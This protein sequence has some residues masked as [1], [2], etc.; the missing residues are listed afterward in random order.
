MGII[1]SYFFMILLV[2]KIFP[3]AKLPMR[4]H[5]DD[6]GLDLYAREECELK[7]G[8]WQGIPTGVALAIPQGCVGLIW[9]K[10]SLPFKFGLKTMGGVIDAQYRGE[11][12]VIMMNLGKEPYRVEKGS[13]IAQILIQKVELLAVE[14][15][16]ELDDTLRGDG[17]FGSTG[18][19]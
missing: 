10:S 11:V 3:E 18:S 5:H 9:D 8:E 13:K 2:K 19:H 17:G 6:A 4:A 7:P 1:G 16:T 14:E 15:A 12:S